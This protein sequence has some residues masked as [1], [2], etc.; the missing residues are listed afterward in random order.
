MLVALPIGLYVAT[1]AALLAYVGLEDP[2]YFRAALVANIAGV[3]TALVAAIPGAI[4]LFSLPAHSSARN[5]GLK[6]AGFALLTT[7]LF[8]VSAVVSWREW[9]SG[10]VPDAVVPLAIAIVG[11]LALVIVGALGWTMVQTH[12]VGVKT[13]FRVARSVR[14]S[15]E[16]DDLPTP[17][18]VSNGHGGDHYFS[19]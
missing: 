12:H 6:H 3:V 11:V 9:I 8:G 18:P 13:S 5:T 2:F 19:Q 17:R 10:G 1:V 14:D 15:E 4:D 7:G 16:L